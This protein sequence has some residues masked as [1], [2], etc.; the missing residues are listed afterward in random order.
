V[1]CFLRILGHAKDST[2]CGDEFVFIEFV[3]EPPENCWHAD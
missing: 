3:E 2:A 1:P